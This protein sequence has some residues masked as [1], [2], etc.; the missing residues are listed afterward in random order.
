[1]KSSWT[2]YSPSGLYF[3]LLA[4][5]VSGGLYIVQQSLTLP[6]KISLG[7]IILG[8]SIYVLLDPQRIRELFR[9]RQAR[10]ANNMVIMAIALFGIFAVINYLAH[11]Y[12]KRW[13]ITEDRQNSLT[14]ETIQTL[15]SLPNTVTVQ[16]FF[17]RSYPSETAKSILDSYQYNS[18]G[19]FTFQFIDPETDIIAAQNAKV[20]RDGTIV[21]HLGERMEQVNSTSEQDLTAALVKLINPG[22]RS[23][24]FLTGHG[25]YGLENSEDGSYS[26]VKQTLEVKNYTVNI[27]N[28]LATPKI[29]DDA[30]SII[31]AGPRQPISDQE[32][33]LLKDFLLKGKSIVYL[34]EPPALSVDASTKDI[35]A[36]Y[37]ADEWGIK[38]DNDV[39]I[40]PTVSTPLIAMAN[41]YG[42]HP[43]TEKINRYASAFPTA[44]SISIENRDGYATTAL[45][46]TANTAWGETDI[47]SIENDTVSVDNNSDFL[48][49][50]TLAVAATNNNTNGRL[51]VVGDSDFANDKFFQFQG[52]ING[53]FIINLI[54]WTAGQEDLI[55]LTPK[56]PT[57]RTLVPPQQY[58]LG[59]LL[60]G[61]VFILPGLPIAFGIISWV[62]RK[63]KG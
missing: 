24:Y 59:L 48:G 26:L 36:E 22:N 9:G 40:D 18:K 41:S 55:N 15:E 47:K 13:D 62:Q 33:I 63:R 25:E 10:Y 1:M 7:C 30:L 19:K 56:Q 3:A 61:L 28:L 20:T 57:V 45:V 27:L 39:V 11:T 58:V 6:L 8:I 49:P 34:S 35:F 44:Q 31:I 52:Y 46:L 43:I 23:V 14:D 21:L 2:K 54:D 51:V 53:D 16:A 38:F 4:A 42:N 32:L 50:L 17:T 37:L 60:L 12:S 5:L 29:P